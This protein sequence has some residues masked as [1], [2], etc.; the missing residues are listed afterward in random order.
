MVHEQCVCGGGGE[1]TRITTA[2]IPLGSFKVQFKIRKL[3][4]IVQRFEKNM[5]NITNYLTVSVLML[6][7]W[8]NL[9]GSSMFKVP[10]IIP[11][12]L[13]CSTDIK[14][15]NG[16]VAKKSIYIY[17]CNWY[18]DSWIYVDFQYHCPKTSNYLKE[19]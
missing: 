8:N 9:P 11:V 5:K 13:H 7:V 19:T 17:I 1:D 10:S 2:F 4:G 6:I 3:F 12:N 15:I 18:Q 16:S 14:I